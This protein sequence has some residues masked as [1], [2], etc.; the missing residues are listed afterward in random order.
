MIGDIACPVIGFFGNEDD[1]PSPEDVDKIDAEMSR[2][3]KAHEFH[4]YDNT[5]HAFQNFLAPDRYREQSSDDAQGKLIEFLD[6]Q[7]K[8]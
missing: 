5:G 4:R 7:F 8:S 2:L 6:R 1:N 3:G